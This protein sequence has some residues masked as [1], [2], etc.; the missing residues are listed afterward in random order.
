MPPKTY[1]FS[2]KA[3]PGYDR[4]KLI[5]RLINQVGY[6]IDQDKRASSMLKVVFLENY[7]V[8]SAEILIP[9]ANISE[10]ISTAERRQRTATEVYVNGALY[11]RHHGRANVEIAGL[12]AGTIYIF[13]LDAKQVQGLYA[14]GA[15]RPGEIYEN[16]PALRRMMEQ[17]IDGTL[18]GDHPKLFADLY[19]SLLFGQW[20]QMADP[21]FVLKDFDAYRAAQERDK[22]L[23]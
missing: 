17:L 11:L 5:I 18:C 16:A 1:V 12:S 23:S 2:G 10:Q 6:L 7:C 4:A 8:S 3:A 19:Q 9:A 20:G 14:H 21:Y 22:G 13:G 15:Y